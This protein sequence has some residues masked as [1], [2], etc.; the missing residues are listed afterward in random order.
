MNSYTHKSQVTPSKWSLCFIAQPAL[1]ARE[2][3]NTEGVE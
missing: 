3:D 1:G 2:G